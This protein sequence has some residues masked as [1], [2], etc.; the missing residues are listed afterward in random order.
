M[1]AVRIATRY[2]TP[3]REG[4]SLPGLME[5]DDLG[6]GRTR[7]LRRS[8]PQ[9]PAG[10]ADRPAR[11]AYPE[12]D[13]SA[14]THVYSY[15]L[16]RVVPQMERGELFNAGVL[17]YCKGL[18]YLGAAVHLDRERLRA[19]DPGADADAIDRALATAAD[20]CADGPDPAADGDRGTRF[21]WLTAPR[22]TV[23]QAGPVHTGLTVD[24]AGELDRLMHA[25]VYPA[26]G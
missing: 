14:R 8:D 22:S 2:V 11:S 21:H 26:F 25:L 3:L 1:L 15:A 20:V 17:L 16:L 23:V 10:Q 12:C 19:L 6:S 5:A 18:D 13:V 4:G 24:P 7:A 9:R